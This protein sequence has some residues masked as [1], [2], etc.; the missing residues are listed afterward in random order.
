[1]T[2]AQISTDSKIEYRWASRVATSRSVHSKPR[3]CKGVME[4]TME[5]IL[6][7]WL[8]IAVVTAI[9]ANNRG[10]NPIVWFLL[11]FCFSVFAL[12]VVVCLRSEPAGATS[13]CP[14][15][16]CPSCKGNIDPRATVCIHCKRDIDRA[17][18]A[19]QLKVAYYR[20]LAIVVPA[21]A[22]VLY[23]AAHMPTDTT[24]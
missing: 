7:L 5:L 6:L 18:M 10:R 17:V 9:I 13:I 19:R 14:G 2:A 23:V 4:S 22:V 20:R 12:I 15:S 8:G 3:P 24:A 16:T 1:M 11:G 21:C